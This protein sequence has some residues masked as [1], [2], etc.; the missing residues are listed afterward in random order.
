MIKKFQFGRNLPTAPNAKEAYEGGTYEDGLT[1]DVVSSKPVEDYSNRTIVRRINPFTG[2]TT[3]V[4]TPEKFEPHNSLRA[5]VSRKA[6]NFDKDRTEYEIL[7]RRFDEAASVVGDTIISKPKQIVLPI[8]QYLQQ[9]GQMQE[10]DVQQQIIQLVQAA[11]Q[12]D[13]QA[14]QTIQQVIQAAEQ[15]DQQA[16]QLAQMIQ[17]IA[18]QMQGQTVSA[19]FGSKLKYIKKLKYANGGKTCKKC[20]KG[21]NSKK[22]KFCQTGEIIESNSTNPK[23]VQSGDYWYE[24]DGNGII[25]NDTYSDVPGTLTRE[26]E[27]G[28][29]I[30]DPNQ[31]RVFYTIQGYNKTPDEDMK[32]RRGAKKLRNKSIKD[33]MGGKDELTVYEKRYNNGQHF[34][35]EDFENEEFLNNLSNVQFDKKWHAGKVRNI[36]HP[37]LSKKI[38]N[39]H[40]EW[41]KDKH[42]VNIPT[43]DANYFCGDADI[44]FGSRLGTI[45]GFRWIDPV[46]SSA[47]AGTQENI[48]YGQMP[49]MKTQ[50]ATPVQTT[51]ETEVQTL[52]ISNTRRTATPNLPVEVTT[53]PRR[54]NRPATR[55]V[56]PKPTKIY[57][58]QDDT[59]NTTNVDTVQ[60]RTGTRIKFPDGSYGPWSYTEW[61]EQ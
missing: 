40:L 4:E 8:K 1:T 22:V 58:P 12:G 25:Y 2:D 20:E 15:G 6:R 59:V 45:G 51:V 21:D 60:S 34:T 17:H 14:A 29:M 55:P 47:T 36:T 57:I 23:Y 39:G 28:N 18:K 11:M 48:E 13:Q 46:Y 56:N 7:K 26:V 33:L 30:D 16:I 9:G 24:Q 10:Q 35:K 52:P 50:Y 44:S 38:R 49:E 32:M 42:Y 37:V 5:P 53:T 3:F 31:K 19:K 43:I 27:T 54:T 61:V 41:D